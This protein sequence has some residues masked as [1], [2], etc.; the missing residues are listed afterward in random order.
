MTGGSK[1]RVRHGCADELWCLELVPANSVLV[2]NTD[3]DLNSFFLGFD[4]ALC[5][6]F[7][8]RAIEAISFYKR[9]EQLTPAQNHHLAV[10]PRPKHLVLLFCL[11][12]MSSC[13]T[14]GT[15]FSPGRTKWV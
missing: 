4:C 13:A 8:V 7:C 11:R 15:G 14:L 9:Q 5:E 6:F 1:R 3:Y 2:R 12:A 10:W